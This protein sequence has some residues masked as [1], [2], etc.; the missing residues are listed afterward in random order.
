MLYFAAIE[1]IVVLR[2]NPTILNSS[3]A[4]VGLLD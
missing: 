1:D 4:A 3:A 2:D